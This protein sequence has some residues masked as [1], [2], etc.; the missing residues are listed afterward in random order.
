MLL[1]VGCG[2]EPVLPIRG[3]LGRLQQQQQQRWSPGG[4]G[5]GRRRAGAVGGLSPPGDIRVAAHCGERRRRGSY[6]GTEQ[7]IGG[8]GPAA[9]R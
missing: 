4:C 1:S 5:R 8:R 3:A 2:L 7:V 6:L 9:G